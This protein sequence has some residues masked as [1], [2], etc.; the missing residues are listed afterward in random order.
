MRPALDLMMQIGTPPA[1]TIV[2]L[3]CGDGAAAGALRSRFPKREII[4]LDA[5]AAMLA[6]TMR[7][8]G[9]RMAA[10]SACRPHSGSG[11]SHVTNANVIAITTLI[12]A[13]AT[14]K[15]RAARL[16]NSLCTRSRR[17]KVRG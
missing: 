6:K 17:V 1:G 15:V 9:P 5:S 2:D 8:T 10:N 7:H 3:G 4:G 12:A 14:I 13:A 16:P 11:G